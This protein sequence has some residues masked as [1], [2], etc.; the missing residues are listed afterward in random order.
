MKLI[1]LKIKWFKNL[2]FWD[3]PIDFTKSDWISIFVWNNWSWKS[4]VLEA[5]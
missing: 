5:I 4:N 2:D 3:N 1:S